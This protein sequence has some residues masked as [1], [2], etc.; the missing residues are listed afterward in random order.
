M[1]SAQG[2][3]GSSP[4]NA[5]TNRPTWTTIDDDELDLP[6]GSTEST[7]MELHD[8]TNGDESRTEDVPEVGE[9]SRMSDEME[10]AVGGLM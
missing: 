9:T 5:P 10:D 8:G 2:P 7:T 3:T 1:S 6:T 4:P